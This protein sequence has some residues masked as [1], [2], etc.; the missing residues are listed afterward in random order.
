MSH[1][2]IDHATV[3]GTIVDDDSGVN[4]LSR[5]IDHHYVDAELFSAV[6]LFF[7]MKLLALRSLKIF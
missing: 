1:R 6:V 5:P 3:S 4:A 7:R 2:V